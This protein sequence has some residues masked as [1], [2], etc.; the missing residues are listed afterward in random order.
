MDAIIHELVN[1]IAPLLVQLAGF[2][3]LAT[4]SALVL[5]GKKALSADLTAN[6]RKVL[7]DLASVAVHFAE[8][9]GAGKVGSEKAA[10]AA[11][12]VNRE[13]IASGVTSVGFADIQSAVVGAVQKAWSEEIGPSEKPSDAAPPPKAA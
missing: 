13:L 2:V 3:V 9:E 8:K 4:V 7:G 5:E 1:Q 6:Q 10:I 12:W 11:A